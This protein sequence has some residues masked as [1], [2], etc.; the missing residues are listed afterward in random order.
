MD[1]RTDKQT[2]LPVEMLF[3]ISV[4][5]LGLPD[6]IHEEKT[7][8]PSKN[9]RI[10]DRQTNRRTDRPSYRYARTHLKINK[11]RTIFS[12]GF[13]TQLPHCFDFIDRRDWLSS[14][15]NAQIGDN[16]DEDDDTKTETD[17]ES[18]DDGTHGG[19]SRTVVSNIS[20]AS[21][22]KRVSK[23]RAS[24]KPSRLSIVWYP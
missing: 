10:T 12:D 11:Q 8:L 18:A 24:A 7:F 5:F 22:V 23:R 6:G 13:F 2:Y 16:A 1:R 9:K 17:W 15:T 19:K 20:K 14:I 3:Y 21:R 4:M